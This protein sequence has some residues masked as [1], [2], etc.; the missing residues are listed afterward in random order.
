MPTL[1]HF[2]A[3][4]DPKGVVVAGAS[5]HPGKFGFV[6]LHNILASGYAGN[7]FA[8]N[9]ERIEVLGI[10]SVADIEDVPDGEADLVF[11]CT[12]AGTNP[13]LLRAAAAKGIRA[14]FIAS[15]GY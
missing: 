9:R 1:K 2:N 7:V 4:F 3:L 5:S 15:A 12:P 6:A 10:Q 11:V 8:T 14:A 13:A